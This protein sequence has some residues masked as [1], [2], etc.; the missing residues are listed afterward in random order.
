MTA[1]L[2][3]FGSQPVHLGRVSR[4]TGVLVCAM[5][6]VSLSLAAEWGAAA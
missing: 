6:K 4:V 5:C 3:L 2:P 1:Q